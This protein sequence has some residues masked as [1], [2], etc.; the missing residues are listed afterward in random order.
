MYELS[1]SVEEDALKAR[2]SSI[3]QHRLSTFELPS[4]TR[5]RNQQA[6]SNDTPSVSKQREIMSLMS[7]TLLTPSCMTPP[8]FYLSRSHTHL[9]GDLSQRHRP[10]YYRQAA[11][12]LCAPSGLPCIPTKPIHGRRQHLTRWQETE[13]EWPADKVRVISIKVALRLFDHI[14]A[15]RWRSIRR[16]VTM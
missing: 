16:K 2:T 3:K 5:P 15:H 9:C 7:A 11:Q 10:Q 4:L 13:F 12:Q 1:Q 8:T 14:L 6:L